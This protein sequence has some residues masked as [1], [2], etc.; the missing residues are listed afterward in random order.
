MIVRTDPEGTAAGLQTLLDEMAADASVGLILVL[1]GEANGFQPASLDALLHACP[2]PLVGGVFPKV[3]HDELCTARGTV[4]AGLQAQVQVL[5]LPALGDESLDAAREAQFAALRPAPGSTLLMF[6]DG[7]NPRADLVLECLFNC[8]GL[9]ISYL[10]AAAGSASFQPVPCVLSNL[11]LLRDAAVVALIDAPAGV[12][13]AHGWEP[14]GEGLKVT[15]SAGNRIVSLDWQQPFA[16]YRAQIEAQTPLRFD[17]T[18]FNSIALRYPF[19]IS[20][21]DC[22]MVV[23][24][25]LLA[26]D[27]QLVCAGAV[28]QGSF[29]Y[30]L[31]GSE[32]TLLDAAG[33]A[34]AQALAMREE[35][36]PQ[37]ALLFID[38]ISRA[39][40]LGEHFAQE[41]RTVRQDR[42][43]I[44][45]ISLGEIANTGRDFL[46]FFNC[47]AVVGALRA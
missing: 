31:C 7:L 30:V 32:D 6:V 12:G 21:M 9:E 46:E 43:L 4:V 2:K 41:L 18:N 13:V 11:G 26:Q 35:M 47:T 16:A 10:G 42:T 14:L 44:G 39:F 28:P 24:A 17:G 40:F 37:D 19:G 15:R 36:R 20:R 38:C 25:P 33:A 34:R 8:L 45:V 22:E 27:G 3:M 29:V 5:T 23:R 1:A